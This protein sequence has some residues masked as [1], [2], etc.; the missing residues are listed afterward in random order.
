[1]DSLEV[2]SGTVSDE[3]EEKVEKGPLKDVI[4]VWTQ[5]KS[6]KFSRI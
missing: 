6:I 2:G 5:T 1:M 3:V 4:I